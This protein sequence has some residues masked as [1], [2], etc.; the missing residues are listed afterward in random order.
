PLVNVDSDGKLYCRGKEVKVLIDIK[1]V[2]LD[3]KQLQDLLESMPGSMI[4]KIEVMTT[5][6]PQYASERGGVINIITKKGKVGFTARINLNYG[7][8]GEA[9]LNGNISYRKINSPLISSAGSGYSEYAGSS[10]SNRQN[11]Y[12]DS[13]SYFNITGNSH[14]QNRRPNLRLSIDY[15][16]R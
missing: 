2:E 8:R 16:L 9:G 11:I 3:S 4:E 7:T 15:D 6:P 5:P 14:S 13:V 10:Y 12:T 1:P